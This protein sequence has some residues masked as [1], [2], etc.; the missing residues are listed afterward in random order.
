VLN[1]DGAGAAACLEADGDHLAVIGDNGKLLIF[2][3]SDLPQM[4]RGKGVKLQSYRQGGLR[5]ATVF[6]ASDGAT[7]TDGAGRVRAWIE[8]RDWLGRRAGAGRLAPKGFP[9]SK[10]FRPK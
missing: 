4:A 7:W 10:R 5:D 6:F 1:V 8:W 2:P 9:A 3:L